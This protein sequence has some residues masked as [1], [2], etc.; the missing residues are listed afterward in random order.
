MGFNQ[1]PCGWAHG[2]A[3]CGMMAQFKDVGLGTGQAWVA[4]L[5][6]GGGMERRREKEME[7]TGENL[8]TAHS[9]VAHRP[10]KA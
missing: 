5:G 6:R 1:G 7:G 8:S 2:V 3:W 4:L 10:P 9:R